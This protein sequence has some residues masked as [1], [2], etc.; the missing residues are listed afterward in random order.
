[1]V[2]QCTTSCELTRDDGG[3]GKGGKGTPQ[4]PL[5][6]CPEPHRPFQLADT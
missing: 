4:V 1:M 2:G 5:L 3:V 6:S